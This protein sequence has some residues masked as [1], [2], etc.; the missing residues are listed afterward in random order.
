MARRPPE[1]SED[2]R[3]VLLRL[4]MDTP[5]RSLSVPGCAEVMRQNLY[6]MLRPS[7]R[8]PSH[9]RQ[10]WEAYEMGEERVMVYLQVVSPDAREM[11]CDNRHMA[12]SPRGES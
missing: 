12:I 11:A 9:R 10:L 2:A 5:R 1:F 7:T 6:E 3:T 8:G 4:L